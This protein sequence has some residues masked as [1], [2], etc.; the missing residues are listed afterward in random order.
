MT[1]FGGGWGGGTLPPA[2]KAYFLLAELPHAEAAYKRATEL[3]RDRPH[4][5]QGL[6]EV[7]GKGA[8]EAAETEAAA[9]HAVKLIDAL[10]QLCELSAGVGRKKT[11]PGRSPLMILLIHLR[12]IRLSPLRNSFHKVITV[13]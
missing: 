7:L 11:I 6:V 2:G 13:L 10:R 12:V 1:R 8:P 4:A 3:A 9:A 5:W